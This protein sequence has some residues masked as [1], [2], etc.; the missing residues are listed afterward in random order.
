MFYSAGPDKVRIGVAKARAWLG[1]GLVQEGGSGERVDA[2]T[3]HHDDEK[4]RVR[5][6]G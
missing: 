2:L 1:L 5:F 4:L 3:L 6:R